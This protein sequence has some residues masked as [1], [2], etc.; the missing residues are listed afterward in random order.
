MT[1]QDILDWIEQ[2][3]AEALKNF[4]EENNH[5][6]N[7][8]ATAYAAEYDILERLKDFILSPRPDERTPA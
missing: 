5:N 4:R 2:E 1:V 8:L 3:S 7:H 6:M